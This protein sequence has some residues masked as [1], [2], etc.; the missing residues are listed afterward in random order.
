MNES[1]FEFEP[2]EPA[3]PVYVGV[4]I[5]LG[6]CLALWGGWLWYQYTGFRAQLGYCSGFACSAIYQDFLIRAVG[7]PAAVVA[8]LAAW[9]ASMASG[10]EKYSSKVVPPLVTTLACVVSALFAGKVVAMWG[11]CVGQDAYVATCRLTTTFEASLGMVAVPGFLYVALTWLLGER[12]QKPRKIVT[13]PP[14]VT[15]SG[16]KIAPPSKSSAPVAARPPTKVAART[17]ST[18]STRASGAGA[19][20]RGPVL[21]PGSKIEKP[22]DGK[23]LKAGTRGA[24]GVRML[25]YDEEGDLANSTNLAAVVL[26]LAFRLWG[27]FMLVGVIATGVNFKTCL[28]AGVL[29]SS[30]QDLGCGATAA[31]S[32]FW[33]AVPGMVVLVIIPWGIA[34]LMA[35]AG[36]LGRTLAQTIGQIE[37]LSPS[38][39]LGVFSGAWLALCLLL[40]AEWMVPGLTAG[41]GA[42]SAHPSRAVWNGTVRVGGDEAESSAQISLRRSG[43]SLVG[44]G[45]Q[46]GVEERTDA[47]SGRAGGQSLYLRAVGSSG[48]CLEWSRGVGTISGENLTTSHLHFGCRGITRT[49]FTGTLE[50][51]GDE[52]LID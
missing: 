2:P 47:W 24:H 12:R 33:L 14:R 51:P 30:A 32:V 43:N 15:P 3:S 35:L 16:Q 29:L 7:A 46:S 1:G 25:E 10:K 13:P 45:E 22:R 5:L 23:K 8:F 40:L 36:P 37:F 44:W 11:G 19:S 21:P 20:I 26:G 9:R 49:R 28:D 50:E 41:L 38:I 31:V 17:G 6:V 34:R 18:G 52:L 4:D 42:T 48:F 27:V 39:P